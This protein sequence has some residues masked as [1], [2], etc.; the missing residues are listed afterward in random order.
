MID[1][2]IIEDEIRELEARG[3][4]TYKL[5]ERLSWLYIVRDHLLSKKDKGTATPALQG[6]EFIELA[7][8]VSYPDFIR[9]MDEHMETMKVLYPKG[10]DSVIDRLAQLHKNIV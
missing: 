1:L 5:C 7:S 3:D 10:Y 4:T 8:G 6:S 2:D 9:V